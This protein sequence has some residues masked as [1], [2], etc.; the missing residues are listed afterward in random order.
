MQRL[1]LKPGARVMALV[2]QSETTFMNGSLGTVVACREDSVVVSFDGLRTS[3][4]P[5]HKWE[6]TVPKLVDSRT[7]YETIGTF[8]QVPLK[9][10]WAIT[11]HKA[12]GQ[13]FESAL[14]YPKCWDDGQ[15]YTALSRLTRVEGLCLAHKCSDNFL[16]AS[17]DVIDFLEGNYIPPQAKELPKPE[18]TKGEPAQGTPTKRPR[19][20]VDHSIGSGGNAHATRDVPLNKPKADS[21][22][23]LR[24]P[25][26]CG[27]RILE[28]NGLTTAGDLV[29]LDATQLRR[30]RGLG[31]TKINNL[32]SFLCDKGI[33]PAGSGFPLSAEDYL[34][35]L[36]TVSDV[37]FRQ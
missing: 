17:Q 14:V 15:L 26:N 33:M 5:R 35:W 7:K 1:T 18:P 25:V 29:G 9:L 21:F 36:T 31:P 11:I 34:A 10:A 37:R 3:V 23:E 20:H 16:R 2:N 19:A 6:V 32:R 4:V 12:Q 30:L 27:R 22:K 28:S 13:T 8:E 24:L